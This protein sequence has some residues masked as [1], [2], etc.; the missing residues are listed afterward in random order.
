MYTKSQSI[1]RNEKQFTV[2][3]TILVVHPRL[4]IL[5]GGEFVALNVMRSAQEA[6][7]RVILASDN[8][9]LA[10]VERVYGHEYVK[11]FRNLSRWIILPEF[12]PFMSRLKTLQ[13]IPYSRRLRH[14]LLSQI[15]NEQ[16]EVMFSTQS[17]VL[18]APAMRTY[19]FCWGSAKDLFTYPYAIYRERKGNHVFTKLYNAVLRMLLRL[20]ISRP[21]VT[22]IFAGS[23]LIADQ[24]SGAGYNA[25]SFYPP[26]QWIF[27]PHEKQL[28]VVQASRLDPGKN[29]ER[30]LEVARSMPSVPFVLICRRSGLE[31]GDYVEKI[32]S[33]L[34]PNAQ[35]VNKPLREVVYY[36][37]ESKVFLY[38]GRELG[39]GL[40][41]IEAM[42]AGCYPLAPVGTGNASVLAKLGVGKC[43]SD[44]SLVE[45]VKEA[46]RSNINAER[47][48]SAVQ[49]FSPEAFRE[50]IN[51]FF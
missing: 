33:L 49:G 37:E 11:V 34:P 50:W 15:E 8:V 14:F 9:D 44:E 48:V 38:T 47:F 40:T 30:F 46:L 21:I 35:L 51:S 39:I 4:A 22:L 45:D 7:H 18:T 28:Q 5:A 16:V 12:K 13:A 20:L 32:M 2:T 6:G 29:L 43:Y 42:T 31:K 41:M 36:Y 23:D 24:L 3:K 19:H 27:E 26:V 10:N 1:F 17:S 25:V